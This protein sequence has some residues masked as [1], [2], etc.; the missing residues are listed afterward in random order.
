MA[1]CSISVFTSVPSVDYQ[2]QKPV[3]KELRMS[4]NT[5]SGQWATIELMGH[6]VLAGYTTKDEQ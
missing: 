4:E 3:D 6:R 5:N 1:A 2:N